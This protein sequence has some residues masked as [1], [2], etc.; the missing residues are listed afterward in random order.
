[1]NFLP[2]DEKFFDLLAKQIRIV[3]DA[4][5]TFSLGIRLL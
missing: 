1:M 5:V 2:R 3:F 4:D